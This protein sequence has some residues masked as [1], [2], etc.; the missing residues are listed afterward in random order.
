MARRKTYWEKRMEQL[1]NAQEKR[2]KRLEKQLR[3]EYLRI[4]QQIKK[5]IA[6][7]YQEYGKDNVIEYRKLVQRLSSS[8]R[9]LLYRNYEEFARRNPQYAH[10]MPIRETIYQLNRLEGLQLSIRM[11][12]VELGAF[13]EEGFRKLLEEVY[14]N[15]YLAT[16][17]GLPN[18]PAFFNIND[19]TLQQTLNEKWINGENFSDRIWANKER[20][21]NLLNNEI[22]DGFI[23][24]D[25]YRTMSKI[26]QHR[27]DVGANE[28]LRL[29]VT[30]SSFALNQANKQAFIDAGIEEYEITA[31][32]DSRTSPMC[33][34]LNGKR[35]RFEDA[36]VGINYPPFHPWCRTTVIPL[37]NE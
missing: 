12:M 27:M 32:L 16:F 8:E 35:F 13:E 37:E 17:K 2:N 28:A 9:D 10:L 1:Y 22:R 25:D 7:Y 23:R 34:S 21:I 26:L 29:I 18:A 19:I 15:G 11:M 33:R 20:L 24:G 3:K 14:R 4:E 30:E 31:V 6:R 5:E 36:K